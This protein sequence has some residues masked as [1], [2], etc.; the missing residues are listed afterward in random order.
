MVI[1]IECKKDK[2]TK[3][4]QHVTWK[5]SLIWYPRYVISCWTRQIIMCNVHMFIH[6]ILIGEQWYGEGVTQ[7][8][9]TARRRTGW[10]TDSRME[11][12]KEAH[13]HPKWIWQ[14]SVLKV[15]VNNIDQSFFSSLHFLLC[16][17]LY[18]V[19]YLIS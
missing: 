6:Q 11:R 19:S 12:E 8:S 10:D 4:D 15:S 7:T 16:K 3:R 14:T 18:L 1:N 2:W 13:L 9:R 5:L 17:V